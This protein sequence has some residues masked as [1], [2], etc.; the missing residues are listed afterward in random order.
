MRKFDHRTLS[1]TGCNYLSGWIF[2][3]GSC[4][5]RLCKRYFGEII[6]HE[7]A[8]VKSSLYPDL[9]SAAGRLACG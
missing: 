1:L 3:P 7:Q 5:D 8:M 9:G 4:S 6:P 2:L